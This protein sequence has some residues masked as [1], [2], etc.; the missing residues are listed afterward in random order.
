MVLKRQKPTNKLPSTFEPT[1]FTVKERNGG[2]IV[3]ENSETKTEYRRNVAHAKK[4]PTGG[5]RAAEANPNHAIREVPRE[6]CSGAPDTGNMTANIPEATSSNRGNHVIAQ[7]QRPK[8]KR[9]REAP[10]RYGFE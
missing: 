9:V 4:I 3:V 5:F 1:T 7:N 8:S 6:N 2:E 10:K